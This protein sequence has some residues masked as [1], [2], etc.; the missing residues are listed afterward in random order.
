MFIKICLERYWGEERNVHV[1]ERRQ[2][3]QSRCKQAKKQREKRDICSRE[4]SCWKSKP[5]A[6]VFY[7]R[8]TFTLQLF[9]I[10][11]VQQDDL[12]EDTTFLV[13]C[14]PGDALFWKCP[15]SKGRDKQ[16][17]CAYVGRKR[18]FTAF[19]LPRRQF[20]KSLCFWSFSFRLFQ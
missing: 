19:R 7:F 14:P 1:W 2:A 10:K 11:L 3:S 6:P 15:H 5:K 20:L 8:F 4:N 17:F 13:F 16:Y 12:F 18:N 9:F